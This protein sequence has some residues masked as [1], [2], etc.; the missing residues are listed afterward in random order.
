MNISDDRLT[1]EERELA[2]LLGR[3]DPAAGPSA[4][5]DADILAM[6]RTAQSAAPAQS[7]A[8]STTT[9][10]VQRV[11]SGNWARRRRVFSSLAAAAS[12]VL[13]VGLAWQLRPVTP[14]PPALQESAAAS[15]AASAP[16][17]EPA[18][19]AAADTVP[20]AMTPATAP[21][22]PPAPRVVATTPA[23]PE[24]PPAPVPAPVIAS[25]VAASQTDQEASDASYSADLPAAAPAYAPAPPAPAAAPLA[26]SI[27][28]E[29]AAKRTAI[30]SAE[31]GERAMQFRIPAP[32][33]PT[34]PAADNGNLVAE[35]AQLQQLIDVS[36]DA[37]LSRQRWLHKIRERHDSG[38]IEG[39]R[40]SLR[41]FVQDYPEARI[42][43]DLRPLLKD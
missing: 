29:Q 28:V 2:R 7:H 33:P 30:S 37:S 38:D 11:H 43:R 6:A 14:P 16:F 27:G 15:A 35:R 20:N 5:L 41:R 39:A 3:P 21:A 22:P 1:P 18:A 32:S 36:A 25:D 4:R 42:P 34:D 40:A 8:S 19:E 31:S 13:V 10:P 9:T 12:L 23:K 26:K 17:S 24:R